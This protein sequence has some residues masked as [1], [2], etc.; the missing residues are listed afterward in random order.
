MPQFSPFWYINTISWAFACIT[1]VVIIN[2][3][4]AFPKILRLQY[5]RLVL[6]NN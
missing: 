1:L 4:L 6:L 2:Q 5:S 3:S